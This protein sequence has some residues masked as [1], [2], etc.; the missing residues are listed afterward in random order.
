[1]LRLFAVFFLILATGC[2]AT[3]RR[4]DKV[5]LGMTREDVI[6]VMGKP[7]STM[8]SLQ[9]EILRYELNESINDWYPATY[10]VYIA[11]GRVRQ[12]GRM[13]IGQ[14]SINRP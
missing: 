5:S 11:N 12:Y 13:G 8:Q 3:T 1:M 10:Y 7:E 6:K 9:G 2:I 14:D 4:L